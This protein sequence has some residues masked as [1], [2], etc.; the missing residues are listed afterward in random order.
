MKTKNK[1][2]LFAKTIDELRKILSEKRQELFL[3]RQDLSQNKLKNQRSIFWK[4]NEI[5]LILTAIREKDLS[6]EKEELI[7]NAKN[8]WR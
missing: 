8:V 1:K 2:E 5:A 6:I 3:L 4:R 7:K